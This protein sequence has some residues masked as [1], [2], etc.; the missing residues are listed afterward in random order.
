[1]M[2]EVGQLRCADVLVISAFDISLTAAIVD[3]YKSIFTYDCHV[4]YQCPSLM[5][6]TYSQMLPLLLRQRMKERFI[7]DA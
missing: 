1:M 2:I 5:L 6:I 7:S 4:C 3:Q